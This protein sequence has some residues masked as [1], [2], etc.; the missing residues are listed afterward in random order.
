MS[1]KNKSPKI[2]V[3]FGTRPELIK[4]APVIAAA[5]TLGIDAVTISSSQH[6]DLLKPFISAFSIK[7]DHD[8]RVMRAGQSPNDVASRA[9][10]R[11]DR[12][13]T[14]VR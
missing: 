12:V 5:K 1:R 9:I 4:L 13:L 10:A 14:G 11:L 7:I 2:A 6:T 8:L 3:L